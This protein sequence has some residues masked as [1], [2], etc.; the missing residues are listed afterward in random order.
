MTVGEALKQMRLQA[1]LTQTEMTA[2][3]VSES[4]YS[5]IERGVHAVDVQVLINILSAHHMDV[6]HFFS[7][8]NF[9]KSETEP[10][11]EIINQIS[12]AQNKKDISALDKIKKE[13]E[14]RGGE[15]Y[16]FI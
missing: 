14:N 5:K 7:L 11:F 16:L 3:V 2:G 10:N 1:G 9:Q 4:F 12:F 8:L 6:V 15:R 13:L